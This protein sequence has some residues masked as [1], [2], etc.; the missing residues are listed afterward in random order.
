M[1]YRIVVKD[2]A[3]DAGKVY[4][5]S[6]STA[7]DV[8]GKAAVRVLA[9]K[10]DV[11]AVAREGDDLVVRL[12]DGTEI[13]LDGYFECA[14]AERADVET[15]HPDDEDQVWSLAFDED[16]ACGAAPV[17][18]LA[19]T[20][21][22]VAGAEQG[23]ILPAAAAYTAGGNDDDDGGMGALPIAGLGTL[24][25]GGLAAAAIAWWVLWKRP[26][27]KTAGDA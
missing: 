9:D 6:G 1:A 4:Q 10:S 16:E 19:W 14:Q 23:A 17:H 20:F 27:E 21:E 7:V 12:L 24:L 22:P 5:A 25:L 13:S 8:R 3:Q 15:V 2:T 11:K 26:D 18:D